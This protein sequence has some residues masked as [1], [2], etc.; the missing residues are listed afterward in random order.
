LKKAK[1]FFTHKQVDY[2]TAFTAVANQ[3]AVE[4]YR[5]SGMLPLYTTLIGDLHGIPD[6]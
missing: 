3:G 1:V 2:Y 5:K 4:F 6:Q